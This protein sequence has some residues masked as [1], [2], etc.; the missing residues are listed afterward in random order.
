MERV[1]DQI[2][3]RKKVVG[4]TLLTVQGTISETYPPNNVSYSCLLVYWQHLL[5]R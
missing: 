3:S 4:Y 1:P 5:E 2:I